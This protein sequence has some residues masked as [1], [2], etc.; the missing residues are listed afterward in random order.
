MKAHSLFRI[1]GI[2]LLATVI[3]IAIL[4]LVY[5]IKDPSP[6]RLLTTMIVGK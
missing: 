5:M 3:S 1:S 6:I 4:T 2:V